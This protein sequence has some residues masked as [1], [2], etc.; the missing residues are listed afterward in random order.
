MNLCNIGHDFRYE[1]EKLIRIFLPFEKITFL[2]EQVCD[3]RCAVVSRLESDGKVTLSTE[4]SLD[5]KTEMRSETFAL[6]IED[7][8][9]FCELHLALQLYDCFCVITGYS[10]DWGVLTGVRPAKLFGRLAKTNDLEF[11]KDYFETRLKVKEN[12]ISLCEET[13]KSE[14]KIV[15]LSKGDSFSLYV[16][17]PFCPSRCSYC[18][19]VSHSVDKAKDLIPKYV[20]LLIS[21]L[22]HTAKIA[23]KLNLRLET[24]Y[25]GGGTPTTLT[26]EQLDRL[27]GAI[28]EHFDL[29]NLREYTVEAG[30]PDTITNCKLK[31]IKRRGATR[32]SI[33]PQ[34]MQSRVLEAIGRKRGMLISGGEIDY[35]R[36]SVMLLDEYRG[37]KLGRLTLEFPL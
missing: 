31:V 9:K 1:L 30:R 21:E 33:N 8:D 11:A 17:I 15:S 7:Y 12:K 36:V 22:E 23:K 24:I 29:S 5:G 25:I 34:T 6:P 19:F 18:S 14:E 27:M 26:H 2:S 20:E 32:I 37:G 3:K 28:Q 10:A 35:E 4:L 16:S 13:T